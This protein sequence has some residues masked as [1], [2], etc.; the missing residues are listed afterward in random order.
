MNSF[1]SWCD[2][3]FLSSLTPQLLY[4]PFHSFA[5]QTHKMRQ[6]ELGS[7]EVK[8]FILERA[9]HICIA[10]IPSKQYSSDRALAK[11]HFGI[12]NI[13]GEC[14]VLIYNAPHYD[15]LW[16]Q[17]VLQK[18]YIFECHFAIYIFSLSLS[19]SRC[20]AFL[21]LTRSLI[22]TFHCSAEKITCVSHNF[23]L[24][25]TKSR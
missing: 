18:V 19:L 5:T 13:N 9:T 24:Y 14:I 4:Y 12:K 3:D 10:G 21:A 16:H 8:S 17:S 15:P 23:S 1:S 25:C 22:T 20:C 7:Y 11:A 2:V 6:R